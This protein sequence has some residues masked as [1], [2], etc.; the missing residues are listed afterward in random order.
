MK[1]EYRTIR[2]RASA[3][4]IERRSR[5]IAHVLPVQTEQEALA[6]INALR[7]EYYDATHN[8]YAY[9]IDENNICRYSD[10]GEPSG[11]AGIPVLDVLRKENLT[12]LCVVVTRYFGGILLGGGGLVRAY[13]ASAKLGVDAAGII[14]RV[15]CDVVEV[16]C[17]YTLLGKL[18]YEAE[19]RGHTI[20]G[21]TYTDRA[22]LYVFTK[23]HETEGFLKAMCEASNGRAVCTRLEQEYLDL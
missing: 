22:Q 6:F 20:K 10:D 3:E 4:M 11:T 1:T 18:R 12:N 17:D 19:Q 9:I 15:L 16:S 5:F 8:V 13:G 2:A 7:S 14:T 23:T 21:I